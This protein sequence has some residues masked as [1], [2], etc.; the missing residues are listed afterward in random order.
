MKPG[1][2]TCAGCYTIAVGEGV[3]DVT[4]IQRGKACIVLHKY[5]GG[6]RGGTYEQVRG[7]SVWWGERGGG[8]GA[9]GPQFCE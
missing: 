6:R 2:S 8:G 9:A 7:V 3:K 1:T 4:Q 5:S